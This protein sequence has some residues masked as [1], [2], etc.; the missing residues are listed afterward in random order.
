MFEAGCE[1]EQLPRP[2]LDSQISLAENC[3]DV[4]YSSDRSGQFTE[5]S[6]EDIFGIKTL[7]S[8]GDADKESLLTVKGIMCVCSD[9][10]ENV[11]S[12]LNL[13]EENSV[14]TTSIPVC[15]R[16]NRTKTETNMAETN[17]RK[18][19]TD[20]MSPSSYSMFKESLL[21]VPELNLPWEPLRTASRCGCG[22]TFSY[23]TRK[24]GS[25]CKHLYNSQT[26]LTN[27]CFSSAT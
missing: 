12:I 24:V 26:F 6:E 7:K 18:K 9:L 16:C 17:S 25:H 15:T 23:S 20:V 13:A 11:T 14:P 3:E 27:V 2:K 1:H 4:L 21:H 10:S 19:P 8:D 5:S 22:V